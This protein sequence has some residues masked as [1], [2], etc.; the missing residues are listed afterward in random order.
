MI[1]NMGTMFFVVCLNSVLLLLYG[2]FKLCSYKSK[3]A[4]LLSRKISRVMFFRW[5]IIFIQEAYLDLTLAVLINFFSFKGFW[6]TSDDT[7]NNMLA[8]IIAI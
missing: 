2:P 6:S 1:M 3:F 7:F 5:Q 4:K 8:V